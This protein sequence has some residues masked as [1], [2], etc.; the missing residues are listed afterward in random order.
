MSLDLNI[1]TERLILRPFEPA[2]AAVVCTLGGESAKATFLPDWVMGLVEAEGLIRHF[3]R[4]MERPDP[5]TGPVVWAVTL[6]ETGELIGHAGVGPKEELGGEVELGYAISMS[7]A[8]RGLATEAAKAAVWWAFERGGLDYLAAIVL[9]ENAAS[10]RVLDKL[11]F[12]PAGSRIIAENGMS[13]YYEYLRFYHLDW[14]ETPE[15]TPYY[16]GEPMGAF[17]DR[18]VDGYEAH[19]LEG[20][21]AETT[22]AEAVIPVAE[23]DEP[24]DVLDLGCGTGLELKW[25]FLRAPNAR[26][27][28]L[29][30]SAGM[31]EKLK[32]N[33]ADRLGQITV[34]QASYIDWHYPAEAYD[35]VLSVNTMHHFLEPVKV[36]IYSNIRK[37]LKPGGKYIE[38]DFMV[39]DIM[40]EQYRRRCRRIMEDAG[41]GAEAQGTLHADMP[42]TPMLQ[43]ELLRHAGFTKVVSHRESIQPRHSRAILLAELSN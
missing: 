13:R 24:I 43:K 3:N 9:P 36:G 27:T 18:R 6:K 22:Y 38:S 23:T 28:C 2:D 29:D 8:G 12:V 34:V 35:Y 26:L 17:F 20:L 31:L 4:C 15:W 21:Y 39:D 5:H 40:M 25:L 41:M 30:L 1:Q 33:Y 32:S 11:G 19:M 10:R 37:A 16:K 7:H 42:L 14:Y